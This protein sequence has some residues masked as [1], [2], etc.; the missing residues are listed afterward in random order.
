[1][2]A[3]LGRGVLTIEHGDSGCQRLKVLTDT[4]D[5]EG[6][7]PGIFTWGWGIVMDRMVVRNG[8]K[9]GLCL[10]QGHTSA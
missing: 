4:R 3:G 2:I 9:R 8:G 5:Q 10:L 6:W 7:Y 1:M